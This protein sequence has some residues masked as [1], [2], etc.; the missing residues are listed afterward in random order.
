M[1]LVNKLLST[2]MMVTLAATPILLISSRAMAE[3]GMDGS[4]IG[5]G[6]AAGVTNGGRGHDDA[7]FGGTL[8]GRWQIPDIST[9]I[10]LRGAALIGGDTVALVP[11]V[12]YDF[13]IVRNTNL[14]AGV[15]YSFLVDDSH[16]TQLGNKDS[17]V[18]TTGVETAVNDD[19]VIFGDAKWGIDAYRN[20]SA[21]AVSL[22]A[23]VGVRF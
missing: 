23:G 13:P 6:V 21:D 9:P 18:V 17:V 1:K 16:V 2:L 8:Q 22:Q 14:Y 15:G 10:S 19:I 5:A 4:Y 20:T 3:P 11:T 12:T 7:Q